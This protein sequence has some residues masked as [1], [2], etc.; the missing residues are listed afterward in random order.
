VHEDKCRRLRLPAQHITPAT[1][2]RTDQWGLTVIL[3][4]AK[5][6]SPF[7]VTAWILRY[8]Q[9]DKRGRRCDPE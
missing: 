7:P 9:N 4:G 6:L 8:P 1:L 3:S 2:Y 5:D